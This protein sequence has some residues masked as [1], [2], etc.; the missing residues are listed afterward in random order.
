VTS[1][2]CVDIGSTFTKGALVDVTDGALLATASHPT[3]LDPDVMNGVDAVLSTFGAHEEVL[4]CSSAGGGLRLAVVGY[5]SVVTAEAGRRVALSAGARVTHVS[6]GALDQ[7]GV[8]AIVAARP[9]AVL[10]VGGTD[11]GNSDVLLHNGR[12]LGRSRL[13]VPFVVA[14]NVDV[15]AEVMS[16][17]ATSRRTAI[18]TDNVLPEIGVL[19]PDAARAAL[20]EMFISHVIGGKGLTRQVSRLSSMVRAAT[21]DAVLS[22]VE[23]LAESVG[24]VLVVDVGGATTDVYSVVD[25]SGEEVPHADVAGTPA[26]L[27][28]VEGDLGVRWSAP[29]VVE[30]ATAERLPVSEGLA[31]VA[32]D[33]HADP[34]YLPTSETEQAT[35]RELAR[36]A[37]NVALRRHARGGRDLRRVALVVGSGGVLRHAAPDDQEAI[38]APATGDLGGGWRVP[39]EARVTTDSS[40]VLAAAG[41]LAP[42]HPHAAR[43]LLRTLS[44]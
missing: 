13:H 39:D 35:D 29:G 5:E 24:D 32:H 7:A 21:P 10:L 42:G 18:A 31:Q 26:A 14:G 30:A 1:I 36:L 27:R 44:P 20:R 17:L 38:L 8:S 16:L 37:V 2:A 22:G 4:A 33:R 43:A 34:S 23:V 6:A 28:T 3:T 9:D 15:R 19:A 41:L 12:A 11:G 40:Y 25:L